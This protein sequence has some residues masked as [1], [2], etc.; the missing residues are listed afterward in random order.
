[1]LN[2]IINI[3]SSWDIEIF[4]IPEM[5]LLMK[6]KHSYGSMVRTLN[7]YTDLNKYLLVQVEKI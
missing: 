5:C 1:M 6:P 7:E 4:Q 3:C 2:V